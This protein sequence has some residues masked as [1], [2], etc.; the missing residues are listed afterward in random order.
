M[1]KEKDILIRVDESLKK[2]LT[3]K[4]KKIGL[5]LSAYVRMMIIKDLSDE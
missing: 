2:N 4:A 3:E 1:K 5:S